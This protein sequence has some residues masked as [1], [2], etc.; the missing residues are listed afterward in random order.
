MPE[1]LEH[2]KINPTEC[3]RCHGH[4]T[5]EVGSEDALCEARICDDCEG[6]NADVINGGYYEVL[7]ACEI[8]RISW[9]DENDES[10]HP[11]E[12]EI[13]DDGYL[14]RQAAKDLFEA[15]VLFEDLTRTGTP[16]GSGD[17]EQL[18]AAIDKAQGETL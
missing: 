8:E 18:Q 4:N 1:K 9:Q 6:K 2:K 14:L 7:Y 5:H 16:P 12:Y 3:P 11:E 10:D 13:Y 15:A 17:L